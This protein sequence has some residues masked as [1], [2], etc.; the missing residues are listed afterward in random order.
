MRQLVKKIVIFLSK[1]SGFF[2]RYYHDW[3]IISRV[4]LSL[5]IMNFIF[6]RIFRI[7]SEVKFPVNYTTRIVAGK[8]ISIKGKGRGTVL[9]FS[10]SN[11]CYIQALNG[12]RFGDEI[13]FAPGV[14]IVSANHDFSD[15]NRVVD[16][17]PIVIGSRV[18]IGANSVILPGV[19]IGNGC[20]IGAGS[21]VTKSFK[22][23]NLVIAGNPAEIVRRK[24]T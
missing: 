6:Q 18:W 10:V 24:E 12:V 23:D 8:N 20:V 14:K 2:K 21:V 16:A 11:N 22:E 9:S 5:I 19:E 13:R 4:P 17:K 7:N 1:F 15:L 3:E